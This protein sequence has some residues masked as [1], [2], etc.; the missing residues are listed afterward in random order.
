MSHIHLPDGVLPLWLWLSGYAVAALMI[1]LLWRGR[2]ADTK[3]FALLGMFSAL[4]ILVMSIE[5]PPY[6][7]N[8]SVV[9]GIVLGPAL[10]I[11]ASFIVNLFLA[12]VGHGGITV[13]GLNTLVI[14]VEMLAGYGIFRGLQR[15][16]LS[17]PV[18]GFLAVV[19]GL[20]LGSA[21]SLG[22]VAL[23]APAIDQ[24]LQQDAVD[25]RAQVAHVMADVEARTGHPREHEIIEQ[26]TSAG[27]LDL[28]RMAMLMFGVGLIGWVL[29][30]ILSAAILVALA[31]VFPQLVVREA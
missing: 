26:A 17:L 18:A 24:K 3:R 2:V 1:A 16:R 31:R 11:V 25:G 14:A 23:G 22:I 4:M 13:V 20:A 30:G 29:E 8:L 28:R 10:A 5:I 27:R 6:H 21:A 12:F 7:M 15:L 9:T 19:L